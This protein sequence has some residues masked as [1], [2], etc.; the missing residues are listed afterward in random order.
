MK[1]SIITVVKNDKDN[2]IKSLQSIIS[3][4][5]S[6]IEHIIFDGMSTDGT[7]FAIRKH[8]KKNTI[9]IRGKDKNYYD[10]LNQAIRHAKGDYVSILNAG[11]E[12]YNFDSLQIISNFLSKKKTDILFGN[13]VFVD[14]SGKKK[15][16]WKYKL[17][18]FNEINSLKIASPTLFIKKK[19]IQSMLYDTNFNISSDLD[20]NIR[21][22][23]KNL[24]FHYI[25][26][27]FI[28]MKLGGLST[29][30]KFFIKKMIQDLN[31]LKKYFKYSFVLI[32]VYKLLIKIS[33]YKK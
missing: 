4:K 27:F 28:I 13:L 22:S 33:N 11:D 32:Y 19:I 25:D 8:I 23:K 12:Y 15:R 3:Q 6:N 29:N 20:F 7:Q 17:N 10:G 16:V 1:F 18:K 2:L 21:L 5:F 9:Y 24:S 26:E 31:I 30:P 14:N